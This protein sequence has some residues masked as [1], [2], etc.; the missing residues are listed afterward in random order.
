MARVLEDL[1]HVPHLK[2]GLKG[3]EIPLFARLVGIADVFDA[4]ASHRVYKEPWSDEQIVSEIRKGSGTQF[5]PAIVEIF[6]K[7]YD[8]LKAIRERF[9][10]P[11]SMR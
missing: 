6:L 8:D 3:E 9:Q 1:Q 2:Q 7:N 4:L 11:R 5:D 10:I